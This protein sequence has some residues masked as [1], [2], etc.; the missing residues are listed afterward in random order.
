M[1]RGASLA[2]RDGPRQGEVVGLSSNPA[3][4][5][6]WRRFRRS[7]GDSDARGTEPRRDGGRRAERS[8]VLPQQGRR[9]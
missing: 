2:G 5:S 9:L 4:V 8:A 7:R 1:I 3:Q 6:G